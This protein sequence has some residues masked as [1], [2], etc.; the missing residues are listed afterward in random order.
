M[1]KEWLKKFQF[2]FT[3]YVISS[4]DRSHAGFYRCI[5]RNR[6]GAL[7]QRSSQLQV[8]CKFHILIKYLMMQ[9]HW[10]NLVWRAKRLLS[11][12][13][14]TVHRSHFQ[15]KQHGQLSRIIPDHVDPKNSLFNSKCDRTYRQVVM[16]WGTFSANSVEWLTYH[17]VMLW[18]LDSNNNLI[19]TFV[20]SC[21]IQL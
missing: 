10:Q 9:A 1:S 4:L 2:S 11:V 17:N 21:T 12:A 19:G 14:N 5:V 16:I 15:T 20:A 3:R 8:A 13:W 7:M 18:V 6:V